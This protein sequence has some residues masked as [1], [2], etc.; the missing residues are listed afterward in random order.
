MHVSDLIRAGGSLE[1]SAY[2]GEAELTRYE[3]VNGIARQ[4]ELISMAVTTIIYNLT[5]WAH[6]SYTP[7]ERTARAVLHRF[8]RLGDCEDLQ[9]TPKVRQG[10]RM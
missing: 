1:D 10:R 6:I 5:V 8:V 4:T 2:G 7:F 3:V 9:S